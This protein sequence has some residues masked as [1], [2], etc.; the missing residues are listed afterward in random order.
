M[1]N[2]IKVLEELRSRYNVIIGKKSL[3]RLVSFVWGYIHCMYD[4]GIKLNGFLPGFQQ[5][6]EDRY[7]IH[8]DH[9]WSSIIQFFSNSDAEAFDLF[10][11]LLDDFLAEN[12]EKVGE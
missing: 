4:N 8:T 11:Q 5:Y 7:N 6:I 12:Q 2:V 10:Y 9:N 3:E 1:D